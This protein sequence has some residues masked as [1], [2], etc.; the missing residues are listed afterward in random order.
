MSKSKNDV[1]TRIRLLKM[2]SQQFQKYFIDTMWYKYTSD[3]AYF[4]A[5]R[6]D[7][8]LESKMRSIFLPK[9]LKQL[10]Q[11]S[12]A[13]NPSITEEN[14]IM[15]LIFCFDLC[16]NEINQ[17]L[18]LKQQY[19]NA[20]VTQKYE[21]AEKTLNEIDNICSS[22]WSLSQRMLLAELSLGL[23][24]NKKLLYE[25]SNIADEEN[26]VLLLILLSYYSNMAE[27]KMSYIN[28]QDEITKYLNRF[29]EADAA[30]Q[31]ISYKCN[32]EHEYDTSEFTC[33][34]QI[35]NQRSIIDLYNLFSDVIGIQF[36]DSINIEQTSFLL[37]ELQFINDCKIRN[38]TIQC[39][40]TNMIPNVEEQLFECRDT[41]EIV[42][43]Y[44]MGNYTEVLDSLKEYL[45]KIPNDFQM[46]LLYIKSLIQINSNIQ[47]FIHDNLLLETIYQLYLLKNTNF[48]E[49]NTI[50]RNYSKRYFG[51][52]WRFKLEGLLARKTGKGFDNNKIFKSYLEDLHLNLKQV[53]Y[54]EDGKGEY[55]K[56]FERW[57]PE[58][59][60]LFLAVYTGAQYQE[61]NIPISRQLRYKAL[62]EINFGDVEKAII[63]LLEAEKST[64]P[65]DYY[66]L[67]RIYNLLAKAYFLSDKIEE[68][69][70]L[71]VKAYFINVCLVQRFAMKTYVQIIKRR[72]SVKG[73]AM[74]EYP[75]FFYIHDKTNFKEQ[76]IA[77]ANFLEWNNIH[78]VYD[79]FALSRDIEKS[80]FYFFLDNVCSQSVLKRDTTIAHTSDDVEEVRIAILDYLVRNDDR[81]KK[82]YMD[83]KN[84]IATE[85]ATRDRLQNIVQSKI[86]IDLDKIVDDNNELWEESYEKYISMKKFVVKIQGYDVDNANKIKLINNVSEVMEVWR[87]Q[88]VNYNQEL[89]V[90]KALIGRITDEILFNPQ[91]GMDTYL[92]SRIRHGYCKNQLTKWLHDYHLMSLSISNDSFE[93][94]VNDYWDSKRTIE[95]EK[96]IEFKERL[97]R[98]TATIETKIVEIRNEWIRITLKEE[99]FGMFNYARF[100][101]RCVVELSLKEY[102]SFLVFFDAYMI[103]F[104]EHTDTL[105]E[106][107]KHRIANELYL[108]YSNEINDLEA[109]ML[110]LDGPNM[111]PLIQEIVSNCNLAK[112]QTRVVLNEFSEVFCK[113]NHS[114]NDFTMNELMETC[115]DISERLYPFYK[116]IQRTDKVLYDS[117]LISGRHFPFFVDIINILISNAIQHS[118]FDDSIG[119]SLEVTIQ[120]I[121][122]QDFIQP[123]DSEYINANQSDTYIEIVVANSFSSVFKKS[124]IEKKLE[125]VFASVPEEENAEKYMQTEGGTGLRKLAKTIKYNLCPTTYYVGYSV[126]SN[127]CQIYVRFSITKLIKEMI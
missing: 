29:N 30:R 77:F 85:R 113:S 40:K 106:K 10:C 114:Y 66:S 117:Q 47:W 38:L 31:Y 83:E 75:L 115:N 4:K 126:Q 48:H 12:Y 55:V 49:G 34:V 109:S 19:E 111:H 112:T 119:L 92:S 23:E 46:L 108:F 123:I 97:S 21:A 86:Y 44:T 57:A 64:L 74:I 101:E 80:K 90:L 99:S 68:L 39:C 118:G 110:K 76:R 51:I 88:D 54:I 61:C 32:L 79:L 22:V 27:Q 122:Y 63:L 95:M 15:N 37:K 87:S 26:D 121:D 100:I 104:W 127:S 58:T 98:F 9:T 96:F 6:R 28:Y 24:E 11:S 102:E 43:L 94:L 17:Y 50:I 25:Y 70:S 67:E 59:S 8:I 41:H 72:I 103:V 82:K 36:R 65:D 13:Y 1:Q 16:K 33:I 81:N 3:N 120:Q 45:I 18:M 116:N 91:Y 125:E 84:T 7:G 107:I 5:L 60:K 71:A 78:S 53:F 20:L 69:I 62:W 124:D 93:Y 14:T 52:S 2:K 89:L 56:L 42:E 35:E 73:K 105:L